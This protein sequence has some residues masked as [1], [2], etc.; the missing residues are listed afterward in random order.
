MIFVQPHGTL[1]S[2]A[3]Y[4]TCLNV[5]GGCIMLETV[6]RHQSSTE[7]LRGPKISVFGLRATRDIS[8]TKNDSEASPSTNR[9][10][11]SRAQTTNESA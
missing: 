10:Y 4:S 6:S 9:P 5:L 11:A 3:I 2:P 8:D 7:S 1:I